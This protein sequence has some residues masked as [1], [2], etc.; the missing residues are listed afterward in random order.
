MASGAVF[1][2]Q[3]PKPE[4]ETPPANGRAA[5]ARGSAGRKTAPRQDQ[6]AGLPVTR[7]SA[8][9]SARS[10][11]TDRGV[12]PEEAGTPHGWGR[13]G[14]KAQ[15]RSGSLPG[16]ERPPRQSSYCR[17]SRAR[18]PHS[19]SSSQ[20]GNRG[21]RG[22]MGRT[23]GSRAGTR[24]Q[25]FRP[26]RPCHSLMVLRRRRPRRTPARAGSMLQG[27]HRYH[28]RR[29]MIKRAIRSRR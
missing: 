17:G 21:K 26:V 4:H 20:P 1:P 11:R 12:T 27:I 8:R 15:G 29:K 18:W 24:R 2:R 5:P 19:T 6:A 22:R 14:R 16:K 3:E 7:L 13:A 9:W 23:V 25:R 28:P 10:A